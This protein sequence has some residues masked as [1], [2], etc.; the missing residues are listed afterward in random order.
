MVKVKLLLEGILSALFIL[1]LTTGTVTK[2]WASARSPLISSTQSRN[3]ISGIVFDTAR[4]PIPNLRIELLD[5]VETR[6]RMVQT[7]NTGR[8]SFAGL[9]YGNFLIR[10]ITSGTNF[11]S[12]TFRVQLFPAGVRGAHQEYL[13][14][15]LRTT[16][17][18]KGSAGPANSGMIF[19]Q[20][21]PDAARK[22]FER[23]ME[24]LDSGKDAE[25]GLAALQEALQLFPTYYLALERLGMERVKR[26]QYEAARETLT[27]ALAVNPKGHGSFY[28]LGVTQFR[29]KQYAPAIESLR[30]MIALSPT[31]SNAPFANYYLGLALIRDGKAG[32]AEAPLR[33]AY[34]A[35]G[36]R[37]PADAH[38]ALAQIYSNS[39]RYKEAADELEI[40]LKET[41]DAR[42]AEKIKALIAQLRA[43]S[44]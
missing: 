40:F 14:L 41:P 26:E 12:Q 7:D 31:S 44:K 22:A 16:E 10:P 39:K 11:V 42:D 5:E 23:A 2:T 17:E 38:M 28:A 4:R 30:K 29:L 13:D 24:I 9:S 20:N 18:V 33:K 21:V 15:V 37:I 19:A 8:Y 32:E 6:L 35:D 36:K 27:K 25:P 43:K 34:E 1:V 3:S